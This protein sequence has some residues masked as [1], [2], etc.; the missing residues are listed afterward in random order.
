MADKSR[1]FAF[2]VY[3]QNPAIW[4][5][6][7]DTPGEE[8]YAELREK[9]AEILRE[10]FGQYAISPIHQPDD[11]NK[12]AHWHVVYKHSNTC[13]LKAAQGIIPS[14][15]PLNGYILMLH[16]PRVYQRYLIHLDNLD[17]EQFDGGTN[18]ILTVNGFPLDL[19]R[20]FSAPELRQMRD[21][22]HDLIR[23]NEIYEYADLLDA[24]ADAGEVDLLDYACN[25][26]IL[27]STYLSSRRYKKMNSMFGDEQSG[28][29]DGE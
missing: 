18:E 9:L 24:L 25:H 27:F 3:P 23:S 21:E 22:I 7:L 1:Y 19:T 11:E 20:E 28:D 17:K 12:N 10:T 5:K 8:D 13:T 26:T 4:E 29:A 2:I 14:V 16:H 15:L 6:P